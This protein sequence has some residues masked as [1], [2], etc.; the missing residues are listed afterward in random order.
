MSGGGE[1]SR[2]VSGISRLMSLYRNVSST[3]CGDGA[4]RSGANTALVGTV[5][6]GPEIGKDPEEP[7][8]EVGAGAKGVASWAWAFMTTNSARSD[9]KVADPGRVV[10]NRSPQITIPWVRT[11]PRRWP[12]TIAALNQ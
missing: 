11:L 12:P 1:G 6:E 10:I 2:F 7:G 3:P 8:E 5:P 4:S 9:K